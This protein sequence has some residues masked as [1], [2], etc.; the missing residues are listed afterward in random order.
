M[1]FPRGIA[2]CVALM[3]LIVLGIFVWPTRY[4]YE[5]LKQGNNDVPVRINRFNGRIEALSC[6]GW[7]TLGVT[8]DKA[9][10]GVPAAVTHVPQ[11]AMDWRDGFVSA[12]TATNEGTLP[13]DEINNITGKC[14]IGTWAAQE[15]CKSWSKC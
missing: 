4:R 7:Q 15:L 11:P 2:L 14:A 12:P 5:H 13:V 10:Q 3:V 1:R 6:A 9:I 8:P